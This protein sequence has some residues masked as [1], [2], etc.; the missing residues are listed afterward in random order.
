MSEYIGLVFSEDTRE[1]RM[2]IS[3][4]D[5][6]HLNDKAFVTAPD[7]KR[8]LV[9]VPRSTHPLFAHGKMDANGVAYIHMNAE[10][11]F[12]GAF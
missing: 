8:R 3:A 10:K 12:E 4:D 5:D 6:A 9:K 2:V 1:L 11:F 7:E